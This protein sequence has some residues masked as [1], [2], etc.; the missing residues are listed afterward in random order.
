MP[1]LLHNLTEL[2]LSENWNNVVPV[3]TADY[4]LMSNTL[5]PLVT[6]KR[7]EMLH[8]WPRKN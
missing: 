2:N 3:G 1:L 5:K 4:F 8:M 6:H 7:Q